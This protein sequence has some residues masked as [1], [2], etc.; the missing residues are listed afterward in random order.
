MAFRKFLPST[1][2]AASLGSAAMADNVLASD[3]QTLM[4]FFFDQGYPAQL[5]EDAV[6]DPLIEFRH[7]GETRALFFYDCV[8]NAGC[9]SLQFYMGYQLGEPLPVEKMNEWNTDERRFTR[10]YMTDD[11]SVRLE[12][13][14][15]T[16]E[17]GISGRD[18]ASLLDLWLDRMVE[19]EEYIGW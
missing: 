2:L 16:G 7:N 12:M 1:V 5:T 4:N 19:F 15:A 6:G 17:D 13:D 9:L 3:P 8:D 14:I 10:G 11:G 18:F